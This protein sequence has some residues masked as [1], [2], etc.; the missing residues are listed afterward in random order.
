MK[1]ERYLGEGIGSEAIK[2][3]Q[4]STSIPHFN[5]AI[6]QDMCGIQNH[7]IFHKLLDAMTA[8][9]SMSFIKKAHET[10]AN[11]IATFSPIS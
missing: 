7:C 11:H 1:I 10:N 2:P 9:A 4:Q 5:S 8:R 3:F 6:I